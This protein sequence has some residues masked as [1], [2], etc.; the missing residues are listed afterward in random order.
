[1]YILDVN[2]DFD[3]SSRGDDLQMMIKATLLLP[4]LIIFK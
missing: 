2:S 4:N 3:C 1:M